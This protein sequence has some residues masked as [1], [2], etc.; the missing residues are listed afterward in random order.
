MWKFTFLAGALR[1]AFVQ[2]HAWS[3]DVDICTPLSF[4]FA[5]LTSRHEGAVAK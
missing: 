5:S 1:T 4:S 3:V 2:R